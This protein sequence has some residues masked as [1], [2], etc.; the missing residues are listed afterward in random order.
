MIEPVSRTKSIN[1]QLKHENRVTYLDE[2]K[3]IEAAIAMN[4]EMADIRRDYQMKDRNSQIDAVNAILT[5]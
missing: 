2:Q 5:S 3:H 1:D 4:N